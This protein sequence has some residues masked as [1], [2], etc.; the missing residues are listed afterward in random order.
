MSVGPAGP[1]KMFGGV[2]MSSVGNAPV[3]PTSSDPLRLTGTVMKVDIDTKEVGPPGVDTHRWGGSAAGHGCC[4]CH[5][6]GHFRRRI[7]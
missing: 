1:I 2:G 4:T 3:S 7:C 6:R 5:G